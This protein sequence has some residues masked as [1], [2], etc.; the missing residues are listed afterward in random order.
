[1]Q[2]GDGK[3]FQL[4]ILAQKVGQFRVVIDNENS[5]HFFPLAARGFPNAS[6]DEAP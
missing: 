1:M 2:T 5:S 3:P 4:Q 6:R